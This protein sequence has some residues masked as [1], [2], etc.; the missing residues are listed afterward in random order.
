MIVVGAGAAAAAVIAAAVVLVTR[1][2]GAGT[3]GAPPVP[4]SSAGS[5]STAPA[6]PASPSVSVMSSPPAPPAA[7]PSPA[8]PSAPTTSVVEAPPGL[9][10]LRIIGYHSI[11]TYTRY[12]PVRNSRPGY[13][14]PGDVV[15]SGYDCVQG[16]CRMDYVGTFAAAVPRFSGTRPPDGINACDAVVTWDFLRDARGVYTGTLDYQPKKAF[17]VYPGGS[18]ANVAYTKQIVLTPITER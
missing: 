7:E 17:A 14:V 11:E 9:D 16:A 4:A 2:S 3:A 5:P 6:A 12:E 8:A 10:P 15:T 18:C 13:P 1:P